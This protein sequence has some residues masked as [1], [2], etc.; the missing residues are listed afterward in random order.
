MVN[1]HFFIFKKLKLKEKSDNR[2]YFMC[3]A[4]MR[5][6]QYIFICPQDEQLK[7]KSKRLVGTLIIHFAFYMN[8]K[9]TSK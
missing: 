7:N 9:E 6:S 5:R 3:I 1:S 4:R 8:A 2:F